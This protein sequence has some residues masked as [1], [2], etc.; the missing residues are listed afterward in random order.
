MEK[1]NAKKS[2]PLTIAVCILTFVFYAS[3]FAA[4]FSHRIDSEKRSEKEGLGLNEVP[5]LKRMQGTGGEATAEK[6]IGHFKNSKTAITTQGTSKRELK[7]KRITITGEGWFLDVNGDGTNVRYRNYKYI[8]SRPEL[9]V[10][11]SERLSNKKLEEL[12][13]KFIKENLSE[14]I[15]LGKNEEIVPFYTEHAIGFTGQA[16]EGTSVYEEKVYASTVVFT[17]TVNKLNIIGPGSK[18]AIMFNN[19]GIPV[20]FDYD[21]PQYIAT[22]KFQKVL[23]VEAIKNR[24]RKMASLNIDSPSVKVKRFDCGLYDA[25]FHKHDPRAVVQ[26]CCAIHSYEKKI[27]DKEAYK[28]NKNSGHSV[29]AYIDFIPAGEKVE[30]DG[31]WPQAMK[32]NGINPVGRLETPREGPKLK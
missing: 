9:A 14:Y 27:V 17:R 22:G 20:G 7:S 4:D 2:I 30:K 10:S 16:K 31:K 3:A 19:K 21:W 15:K 29:A 28:R 23:S 8:D 11:V 18:I 5:L 13:R 1:L 25:G 24:A 26:A 32:M 12:G 6:L